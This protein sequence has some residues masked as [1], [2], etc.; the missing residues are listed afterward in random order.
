M[1]FPHVSPDRAETSLSFAARLAA[2]HTR[3]RVVPFLN[4]LGINA[5]DFARGD[6]TALFDLC[7]RAGVRTDQL[8]ANTP[9]SIGKGRYRLREENISADFLSNPRTV[10][11]PRCLLIDDKTG[12]M[13]EQ[14]R[15]GRYDWPLRV[16]RTCQEHHVALIERPRQSWDDQFHELSVRVPERGPTLEA[17]GASAKPRSVSDLQSYTLARLEGA[18][19]PEWMDSQTIEQAVRTAELLGALIEFGASKKVSAMT[20]DEWDQAGRAGFEFTCRG[21]AGIHEALHLVQDAFRAKGKRPMHRNVFGRLYEWVGA[22]KAAKEPGDIRRIVREHIFQTVAVAPGEEVLGACLSERRLHSVASLAS[23]A[24]LHSKTLGY[25]LQAKGLVSAD[26]PSAVIDAKVGREVAASVQ[27]LVNVIAVPKMLNCSRPQATGLMDERILLPIA[28]GEAG[29]PGRTQKAV[30][31]TSVTTFLVALKAAARPV[32]RMPSHMVPIAK[33][34]E[35]VKVP[36]TD[37]VHMILGGFLSN[38][39]ELSGVGGYAAIHVDPAEVGHVIRDNLPGISPSQAAAKIRIPARVVWALIDEHECRILPSIS[40]A[41]RRG[42]HLIRRVMLDDIRNF[43][44]RF[45][46]SSDIAN[47]LETNRQTVE[48]TLRRFRVKS[49]YSH[50]QIGMNLYRPDDLPPMLRPI[51]SGIAA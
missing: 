48:Q 16:V 20:S 11:C 3:G 13:V 4:D 39:E 8:I 7:E 6:Q 50:S 9:I 31:E 44:K 1:L 19:G 34:A 17:L 42:H 43:R 10:F 30:N 21:E 49:A 40:I 28:T 26:D 46:T 5:I 27:R 36:C 51:G 35:K 2:I 47:Q 45:V 32:D 12:P 37:I 29:A 18:R 38:V 41:G 23:E 25:V 15:I 14:F 24:G 22:T 33:A